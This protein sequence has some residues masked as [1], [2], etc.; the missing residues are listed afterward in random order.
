M[1]K[2]ARVA[3]G[4]RLSQLA[5][6]FEVSLA[7]LSRYE[8]GKRK[9]PKDL[10]ERICA[11]LGVKPNCHQQWIWS[12]GKHRTFT[13]ANYWAVQVDAG[14]TWAD[15][16]AGY[17]EFYQQLQ[18]TR[19]APLEFQRLVRS[20]SGLEA[21]VNS[22][23]C[24]AG[25]ELAL[26][27]PVAMNYTDHPIVREDGKLLGLARK[28]AFVL[29]G[30]ILWPQINL[31]VG[32]RRVRVDFLAFNGIRWVIIELDGPHHKQSKWDKVRDSLITTPTIRFTSEES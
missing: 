19:T 7:T 12:W 18:P 11:R 8:N 13:Q 2:A 30:W 10:Q 14:A 28:A 1:M 32:R 23:L 26:A 6:E 29:D 15:K 3:L 27:S 4:V 5:L 25:A 16:A 9:W 24:E 22:I 21:C 17:E 31:Q 20:D